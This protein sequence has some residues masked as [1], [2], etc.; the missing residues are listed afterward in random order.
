MRSM[1][2]GALQ[3]SSCVLR[4]KSTRGIAAPLPPHFVRSPLPAIAG[5]DA[6]RH[7]HEFVGT[8]GGSHQLIEVASALDGR[9][10]VTTI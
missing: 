6:M 1:V 5:W 7:E 8:H 10:R 3:M 2:E 4:A 9:R